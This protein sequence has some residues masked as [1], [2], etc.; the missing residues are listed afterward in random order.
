MAAQL[1]GT[2]LSFAAADGEPNCA[3]LLEND[4]IARVFVPTAEESMAEFLAR[5]RREA[6]LIHATR[7]FI[8]RTTEVAAREVTVDQR[9]DGNDA[10][11]QAEA[12]GAG[13]VEPGLIWYAADTVPEQRRLGTFIVDG[14]SLVRPVVGHPSQPYELFDRVLDSGVGEG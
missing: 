14:L 5:V 10:A 13:L 12:V 8:S 9:H 6:E 1:A 2:H 11:S 4:V 7:F 3:A